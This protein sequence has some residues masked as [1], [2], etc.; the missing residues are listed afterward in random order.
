[1]DSSERLS[2]IQMSP[3]EVKEKLNRRENVFLLDVRE[4]QEHAIARIEGAEL[5]PLGEL[6]ARYNELDM[7]DEIIIFC[8]HGVRSLQAA[9]F[10][11]QKGFKNV[12]NLVG[13]IDAWSIQ[14]DPKTPRYGG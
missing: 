4:P 14:A 3:L 1:M 2:K 11:M 13:G 7:E 10:L 6:P 8:H 12:K 5:I 9:F